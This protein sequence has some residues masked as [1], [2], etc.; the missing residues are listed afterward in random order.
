MGFA[1]VGVFFKATDGVAGNIKNTARVYGQIARMKG[2]N[3]VQTCTVKFEVF[4]DEG[5]VIE[6]Q[7]AGSGAEVY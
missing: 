6:C 2:N 3:G 7:C 4:I 5:L 1:F